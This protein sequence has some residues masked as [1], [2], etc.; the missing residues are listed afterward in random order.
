M[1]LAKLLATTTED[2]LVMA[3]Q[4]LYT[5]TENNKAILFSVMAEGAA[6]ARVRVSIMGPYLCGSLRPSSTHAH[7]RA[8]WY[9]WGQLGFQYF[10]TEDKRCSKNVFFQC[11]GYNLFVIFSLKLFFHSKYRGFLPYATFGTQKKTA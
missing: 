3:W 4:I 6:K 9:F 11:H 5:K 10:T 7:Y 8:R 2:M 1:H